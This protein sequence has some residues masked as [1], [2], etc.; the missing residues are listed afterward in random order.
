MREC[1]CVFRMVKDT[2][3][4]STNGSKEPLGNCYNS[5]KNDESLNLV[6]GWGMIQIP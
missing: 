2:L 4:K 3:G 1:A 5:L 6:S